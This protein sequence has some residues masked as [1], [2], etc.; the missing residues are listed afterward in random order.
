MRA[1]VVIRSGNSMR[2][3]QVVRFIASEIRGEGRTVVRVGDT[4]KVGSR[5]RNECMHIMARPWGGVGL[6]SLDR[7]EMALEPV[8]RAMPVFR[9]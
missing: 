1:R 2:G 7:Y 4:N 6:P 3:M 8:P 5:F 9:G